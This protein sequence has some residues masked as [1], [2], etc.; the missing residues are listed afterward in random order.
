M[1]ETAKRIVI[2]DDEP[3]VVRLLHRI[4]AIAGYQVESTSSADE[5]RRLVLNKPDFILMDLLMPGV[6]GVELLRYLSEEQVHA[7]IVLISGADS[8]VLQSVARLAT[9]K[10]LNVQGTLA[11]PFNAAELT[12]ILQSDPLS[13]KGL[14][15]D[16]TGAVQSEELGAAIRNGGLL[17]YF[18]PQVDLSTGAVASCEA[19]VRWN[20]PE[21]GVVFP[22]RFIP[23]AEQSGLM[24]ELTECVAVQALRHC[25][26]LARS[27]FPIRCSINVSAISLADVQFPDRL[28]ELLVVAKVPP[29]SVVVE[30]TESRLF[31]DSVN[32]VDVL[33]RL[34]MK[35]I[36]LSIDDFGTGYSSLRQLKL[37]PFNE[38]KIDKEFVMSCETNQESESIVRT[39]IEL[40]RRLA[41]RTVAEG[42]ESLQIADRLRA[43]GCDLGQG[44]VYAKALSPENF[45]RWVRERDAAE[46]FRN[47]S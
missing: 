20:H 13:H 26:T 11:K 25:S 47:P 18:Q 42:V 14:H 45:L 29:N 30:V 27:G 19:L 6:D 8:R 32:A 22:D 44:Y 31:E 39:S 34:R 3:A 23:V 4:C 38:L 7:A 28:L 37:I 17:A 46:A 43:W 41:L 16:T 1:T 10:G 33:N 15:S 24:P 9:S 40:A 5:F 21:W 2:I 12:R 35:G 36:E